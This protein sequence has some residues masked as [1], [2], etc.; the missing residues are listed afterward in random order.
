MAPCPGKQRAIG[1]SQLEEL[2]IISTEKVPKANQQRPGQRIGPRP[3][4]GEVQKPGDVPQ[5]ALG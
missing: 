1:P 3:G 4:R 2:S 5:V